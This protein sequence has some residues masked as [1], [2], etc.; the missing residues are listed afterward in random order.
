MSVTQERLWARQLS[1]PE[2][3]GYNIDYTLRL[4]GKLDVA[5]L[6]R[7][8]REV[9]RRHEVLRTGFDIVAGRAVQLIEESLEPD[10]EVADAS[11]LPEPERETWGRELAHAEARRPFD[12][13]RA[14]LLRVGLVRL[15]EQ[16]HLFWLTTHH[17]VFDGSSAGVLF[18]EL[19]RLYAAYREGRPSPLQELPFQYGDYA[20]WEREW[21]QGVTLEEQLGYWLRQLR[22]MKPLEL[23]TDRPRP[24]DRSPW[25]AS[26]YMTLPAEL[27]GRLRELSWREGVT[28][29]MLLLAAFNVLLSG[30]CKQEDVCVGSP[31]AAR[32][33]PG[34]ES[35]IG[36]FANALVLR[37]DL[38]GN[39]SFRELL[40]RVRD[41][42]L[43][44]YKHQGMR[45]EKLTEALA[46]EPGASA[47]PPF[48]V[49]FT[50]Q[51]K[52]AVPFEL[53]GLS[54]RFLSVDADARGPSD[55][56]FLLR[57]DLDFY[58]REIEAEVRGIWV[59]SPALFDESTIARL[60][61]W[62]RLIL[63]AAVR[64]PDLPVADLKN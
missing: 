8:V 55:L 14:P 43:G 26:L 61:E 54:V 2:N 1:D 10:L 28:L 60:N 47:A 3:V 34:T 51:S 18:D 41:V 45:F 52:P 50:L 62:F 40:R 37:T 19:G 21:L 36:F 22:G 30:F 35:L 20:L 48:R 49:I 23:P 38:G 64:D 42:T 53:P 12:L 44:A 11:H 56:N 25:G 39:P 46:S 15:A 9:V 16:E 17:I 58:L 29:Y 24:A 4:S 6:R 59:Y 27:T 63:E 57:S 7:G 31:A 5:A 32:T 13:R 33:V